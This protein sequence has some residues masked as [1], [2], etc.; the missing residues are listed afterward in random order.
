MATRFNV[1]SLGKHS[2][3]DTVEGH[4]NVEGS[5]AFVGKTF[6]SDTDPLLHYILSFS[7]GSAGFS[8]GTGNAYDLDN[9]PSETFRIDDGPDQVFDGAVA[10]WATLT[11]ADGSTA[12]I[13]AVI[14]QDTQGNTYLAPEFSANTDQQALDAKPI[15]SMTLTGVA[16]D[17]DISGLKGERE[18]GNFMVCFASGTELAT[19][20]GSTPVERLAIGD[21][22]CTLDNSAQPIRWIGTRT[23]TAENALR[24]VRILAGALGEGLPTR[25]LNV[26]Q[27]H[28]MLS[29]SRIAA[30]MFGQDEVLVAAKKLVGL[31]GIC[32]AQEA[33]AITYWH[34]LCDRHEIVFA[35]GAPAETLF[36]GPQACLAMG[37]RAVADIMGRCPDL[38]PRF[39]S[40][41][42]ARP[43]P[44][45]RQQKAFAQRLQKNRKPVVEPGPSFRRVP[46]LA[47]VS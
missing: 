39:E 38:A 1:I 18:A 35:D 47:L 28:R 19:P 16:Q 36:I 41:A 9:A 15:L 29:R 22:V 10:F 27:Q 34:V 20:S 13:S 14:L 3:L 43:L 46:H 42:P 37:R 5:A 40:D 33:V 23:V 6:G 4:F 8:H 25:D 45:P 7:P 31:P 17:S 24:P 32:L 44:S 11:Y 2:D 12:K 26:S 21:L 30:R